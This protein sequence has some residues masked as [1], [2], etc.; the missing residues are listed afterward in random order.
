VAL[1]A[2][3]VVVLLG[4]FVVE[5][6]RIGS[7]SMSPTLEVGQRVL[8]DK[9]TYRFRA[10]HDGELIAFHAPPT[11]EL[12][13]KRVVGVGGDR[14]AIRDGVL[15]VNGDKVHEPYVDHAMVDSVYFGPVVV[16]SGTVFVMGDNRGESID[17]RVYGAV[18]RSDVIGRVIPLWKP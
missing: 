7:N 18:P 6:V 4:A 8:I 3:T 5:P 12:T 11:G 16:P 15:F 10:P 14:V 9:A 1:L 13:V 17:S 2:V